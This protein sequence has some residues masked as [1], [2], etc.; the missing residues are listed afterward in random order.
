MNLDV[1]VPMGWLFLSLGLIL[2][3]YGFMGDPAI[4]A[5]HSLGQNVN[6]LW[7]GIFAAFGAVVL[8]IARISKD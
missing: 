7:G 3:A 4:Y 6:L 5:K 1:R 2:V 8:L